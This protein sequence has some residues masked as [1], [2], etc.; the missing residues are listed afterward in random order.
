MR[1]EELLALGVFG[2]G[3]RLRERI[4][5]LLLRG[6][7]F[8]SR[9]SKGRLAVGAAALLGCVVAGSLAPR[10]IAF[11][12]QPAF[13]VASV[14]PNKSGERGERRDFPPGGRFTAASSKCEVSL[15]DCL[16]GGGFSDPGSTRMARLRSLRHR[17][18]SRGRSAEITGSVDAPVPSRRPLQTGATSRNQGASRV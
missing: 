7:D 1:T 13:E 12:Q 16:P 9:V 15:E 3:S 2:R 11:A 8:S 17:S 4:E 5:M 6:R 14:R 10:W 18:Q